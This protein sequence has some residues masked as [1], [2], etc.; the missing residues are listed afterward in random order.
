M[1]SLKTVLLAL[2]LFACQRSDSFLHV[3]PGQDTLGTTGPNHSPTPPPVHTSRNYQ[4]TTDSSGSVFHPVDILWVIDNSGS[5]EDKQ[6]A[7]STNTEQFMQNFTKNVN[8]KWKMGLLSTTEGDTPYVGFTPKTLLDNTTLNPVKTFQN[9]VDSLGTYGAD[10]EQSF[11]PVIENLKKYP[12]FL[13]PDAYLALVFVSDEDEQSVVDAQGHDYTIPRFVSDVAALK[14][15]DQSKIL[16]YGVFA[17][18][19]WCANGNFYY[20]GSRWQELIRYTN[21]RIY[22]ACDPNFGQV[23][24]SMGDDLVS[25]IASLHPVVLLDSRPI[26]TTIQVFY[27]GQKLRPGFKENGGQWIYDPSA[28]VIRITDLSLLTNTALRT[29]TVEF[30]IVPGY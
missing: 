11:N 28:N 24:S 25:M 12:N 7:V 2:A 10:W 27:N 18:T 3:I 16:T 20:N 29:I 13:R 30:D 4:L 22:S 1:K 26:A 21:G 17:P 9:A 8:I 5:M 19:D 6:I 14:G 15:G 23:L